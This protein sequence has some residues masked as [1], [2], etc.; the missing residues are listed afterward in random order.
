MYGIPLSSSVSLCRNYTFEATN[1]LT[2]A[3]VQPGHAGQYRCALLVQDDIYL[4]SNYGEL[5]Y[6]GEGH[7]VSILL[8]KTM[9]CIG[10]RGGI[11]HTC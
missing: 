2:I 11:C 8:I 1:K 6:L 9:S 10:L 7:Y 4:Y 5:V 3:A